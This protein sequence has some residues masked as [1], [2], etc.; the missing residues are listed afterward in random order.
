MGFIGENNIDTFQIGGYQVSAT[1]NLR[2]FFSFNTMSN[3]GGATETDQGTRFHKEVICVFASCAI[4]TNGKDELSSLG[5]RNEGVADIVTVPIGAG[6]TGSFF[7]TENVLIAE[8]ADVMNFRD[9]SASTNAG[10]FKGSLI[11]IMRA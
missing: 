6:L 4:V 5:I 7:Q 8:G 1:N 3:Q 9:T 2:S 11:F 10:A